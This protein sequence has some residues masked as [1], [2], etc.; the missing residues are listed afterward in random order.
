MRL[1]IGRGELAGA[2]SWAAQSLPV[3]PATAAMGGLRLAAD[4]AGLRVSGFDYETAT[5]G[6]TAAQV[7]SPGGALVSGRLLAEI[8]LM[9]PDHPVE[10]SAEGTRL[11]IVCGPY[12]Y[13]LQSL[14]LEDYPDPPSPPEISGLVPAAQFAAAAAQVAVAAGRDESL[15][16]LTGIRIEADG[17]TLRLVATDRYRLASRELAWQP[18]FED[19]R[20]SVLVPA[21]TLAAL[22]KSLGSSGQVALGLPRE[23]KPGA[24]LLALRT[25][26]RVATTR[27]LDGEFIKYERVFPE[28]YAGHVVVQTAALV[29]A[30][31][32]TALIAERNAP[33]R[34]A[35]AEGRIGVEA[36]SDQD[37][38]AAVAIEATVSGPDITI[39]PNPGYLLDGLAALGTE[40]ARLDYTA[41]AQ[42]AVLT[43]LAGPEAEPDWA[44]RYLFLPLR[45]MV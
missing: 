28:E 13:G 3:R 1:T 10:L 45:S 19:L 26:E 11:E 7:D 18:V 16:F 30:V 4:A 32:R 37:G 36:G 34:L 15:P 43:G 9:L 40:Y 2:V 20:T 27:L 38:C 14:A 12:R 21:R 22:A 42:P 31:R 6:S 44:Y 39:A 41:P 24:G 8:V 33:V 25:P 5:S 23:A 35:V 17:A 29:G